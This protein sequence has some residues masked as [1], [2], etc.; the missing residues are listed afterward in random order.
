DAEICEDCCSLALDGEGAVVPPEMRE[1]LEAQAKWFL[2]AA[3]GEQYGACSRTFRPCAE[4]CGDY[5]GGLPSPA[6]IDGEWVN[7]TCGTCKSDC[8]CETISEVVI[9]RTLA[10]EAITIDG[11]DYDP[12][13]T[14]AVYDRRRIVRTD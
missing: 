5:W 2:W 1:M 11:E 13:E 9:P 14:V 7:L 4:R 10:V 12:E 3:T 6:R 8:G